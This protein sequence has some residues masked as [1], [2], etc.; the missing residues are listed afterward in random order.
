MECSAEH[1]DGQQ[2]SCMSVSLC[3]CVQCGSG[4]SCGSC[5][6]SMNDMLIKDNAPPELFAVTC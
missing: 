6:L 1:C 2:D 5:L 4:K 3:S